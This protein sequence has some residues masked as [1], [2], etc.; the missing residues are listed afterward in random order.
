MKLIMENWNKFQLL[1]E[2]QEIHALYEAN[3]ITEA[4][5]M[6]RIKRFAKKKGI[7]LMVALSLATGAAAPAAYA[8]DTPTEEP[9]HHVHDVESK[10]WMRFGKGVT[11]S[12]SG[13]RFQIY[14]NGSDRAGE[15]ATVV[16][17]KGIDGSRRDYLYNGKG[18]VIGFAQNAGADAEN[19]PLWKPHF[20]APKSGYS[21]DASAPVE[22]NQAPSH[23]NSN[24][25]DLPSPL[26]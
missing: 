23:M 10:D 20:H 5:F 19:M 12:T 6:D 8:A 16:F 17:L 4:E 2:A 14:H 26:K 3:T 24:L 7:P 21:S 18:D 25:H 11:T 22:F 13:D 15:D 1:T 9:T